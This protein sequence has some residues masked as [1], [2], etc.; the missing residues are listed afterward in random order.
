MKSGGS[1]LKNKN[2]IINLLHVDDLTPEFLKTFHRF[3]ETTRVLYVTS[4]DTLEQ[5]EDHFIDHWNDEKKQQVIESLKQCI[6]GNGRVVGAYENGLLIGF[7][8]I[9]GLLF[10]SEKKY[11]E[12]PFIHVSNDKRG[13]GIGRMLFERCCEEARKLGAHKLYI[14]AHPSIETQHFYQRLGCTLA[15]EINP[16]ILAKEPLDIQLE[17]QLY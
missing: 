1:A 8:N 9:E 4:H 7:A 16:D 15:A 6:E 13:S 17:K 12:L 14:A 2:I 11:A 10:G 3:Q 5:K